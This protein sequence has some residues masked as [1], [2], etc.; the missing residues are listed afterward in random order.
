M[1]VRERRGDEKVV[2]EFRTLYLRVG[3]FISNIKKVYLR[4]VIL[5]C[6]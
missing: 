2:V 5:F 3:F 1:C 4:G 6:S